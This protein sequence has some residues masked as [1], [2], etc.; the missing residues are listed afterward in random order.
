[1]IFLNIDRIK[2]KHLYITI[3]RIVYMLSINDFT[4]HIK[5][6]I[7]NLNEREL[8]E[9]IKVL[10]VRNNQL[11]KFIYSSIITSNTFPF[12]QKIRLNNMFI[13]LCEKR[14]KEEFEH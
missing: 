2:T 14:L 1:M 4:P 3:N 8:E 5:E 7:N 10:N 13:S 11:N 6:Q 12:I 9:C